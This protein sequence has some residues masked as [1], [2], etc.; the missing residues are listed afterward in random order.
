[1][2]HL[3]TYVGC[4]YIAPV[5]DDGTLTGPW[6]ELG[7]AFPLSIQLTDSDP[8]TI[9][10]RTCKTEGKVIGS[11]PQPGEAT[12]SLTM[13]EYTAGNVARALK[14]MV[15]E[16]AVTEGTLTGQEVELK[17]IGQYADIG[18]QNLSNI[19]VT[20]ASDTALVP[21]E[22]YTINPVLGL[23]APLKD[24]VANTT[25][26]V[27][28]TAAANTGSRVL[29]GAG[30]SGKYAIK[31]NLI[32]EFTRANVVIYLRKVLF[33]SNAE[34]NFVS[35]EDTDHE[36]MEMSL[37]PEVPTGMSDYGTIDGLPL[38]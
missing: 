28:G 7:E 24:T 15:T 8:V 27:S 26:K 30:V 36:T 2:A 6:E 35:A 3:A 38:R 25:V 14:G 31:G 10:G 16:L 17:E 12:G 1:M 4:I 20:T 22:D 18:A 21:D 29:I 23:I 19:S 5:A 34:I 33:S 13:H 37:T 9:K 32:N 11:K